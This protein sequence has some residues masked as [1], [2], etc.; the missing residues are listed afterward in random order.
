YNGLV[1][2]YDPIG[3]EFGGTYGNKVGP[4]NA[5]SDDCYAGGGSSSDLSTWQVWDNYT[6]D[7]ANGPQQEYWRRNFSGI[8]RAN[9]ILEKLPNTEMDETVKARLTAE[10][11]FLR[12]YYYFDLVRLFRNVPLFTKP[13]ITSEI[14]NVVQAK[15]EAVYAQIETDLKEAI[16]DLPPTV[17]GGERGRA[18]KGAAQALLGKVYLYEGKFGDAA[19]QLAEVNGT[20]GQTSQYGFKLLDNFGD[21]W[22][23]NNKFNSESI[24]EVNHTT[25]SNGSWDCIGCTEG[26]VLTLMV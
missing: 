15:P 7:P 5:A 12:A 26:N 2:A 11:K 13:V 23:V 14:Y 10:A 1:A 3:W 24:F 17:S 21:L 22:K 16:P 9:I 6:L 25:V 4:L 8:A 19:L 18:T 20:P